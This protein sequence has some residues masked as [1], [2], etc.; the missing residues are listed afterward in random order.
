MKLSRIPV[1]VYRKYF[2]ILLCVF[3]GVFLLDFLMCMSGNPIGEVVI[4][5]KEILP[6]TTADSL[7]HAAFF[8]AFIAG[9]VNVFL[10]LSVIKEALRL[11]HWPTVAVVFMTLLFALELVIGMI[12]IIPN[13]II[14]GWKGRTRKRIYRVEFE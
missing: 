5:G 4:N 1:N 11:T 13:I 2:I 14:F 8:S 7:L 10:T 12:F 3:A 9:I 6:V